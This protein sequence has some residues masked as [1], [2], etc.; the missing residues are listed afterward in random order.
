[1]VADKDAETGEVDRTFSGL[2]R[3]N[4][5][6]GLLHLVQ[7]IV[8]I[9]I[10]SD[11]ALPVTTL[12]LKFN[13]EETALIQNLQELGKLTIGPVVGSF[14]LLSA[15]AHFVVSTVGYRWYV[16]NLK[17]EINPAR[18]YE[19]ALSSSVM[20]VVIA[21]LAGMYDLASLILI[22]ALNATMILFGMTME[23]GNE[24]REDVD[25]RPFIYGCFAG[26]VPW[27]AIALYLF[28]TT[29]PNF[30]YGIFGSIFFFF[31]VFALNMY[32]QYK[33]VG[34]WED[35][36]FGER[37]YIVLSLVAKTLLAWQVFAGTLRPM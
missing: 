22:F 6:M 33:K 31:N 9:I 24:D 2:R 37:A 35:Y 29:P 10:S 5:A 4:A 16:K 12:Y 21:M 19:Y 32:L 14:L 28:G 27:V 15:L 25:W 30:V 7:G 17:N 26:L 13:P 34:P 18:W 8:M 36:L 20:I 11:F 3:F 1:M 23:I